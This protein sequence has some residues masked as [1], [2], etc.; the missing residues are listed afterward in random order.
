[1]LLIAR[2]GKIA[3]FETIGFMDPDKK[4]AMKDDAIFRIFSMSKPITSVAA[5][6]L[7]EQ[8]KLNLGDPIAKYLPEFAGVKVMVA[9]K[10]PNDNGAGGKTHLVAPHRAPTVQDLLR[11]TAGLTYGFWGDPVAKL[12]VEA[13]LFGGNYDNAE[14]VSRIAKLPLA[15]QPGTVWNYSN[16]V[17]VLGRV[18][19]VV[20]G[21]SLYRFE[22]ENILDPLGMADTSFYV[23]DP[24]KKDRIAEGLVTDNRVFGFPLFDPTIQGKLE[25]GGQGMESTT[26]DYARFLQMLLNGGELD[27]HRILAPATVAL[28]THDH[29]GSIGPSTNLYLPGPGTG[30]GLGFAVRRSEGV[31]NIAGNVGNYFWGGAAGTT[32]WNDPKMGMLVVFMIQAPRQ[33]PHYTVVLPDMVYAALTDPSK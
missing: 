24:A 33:G 1:T 2:H 12:Y 27:E 19:E 4:V 17:D 3:Y 22:K 6:I 28:M 23:T 18:V 10:D 21:K 9:N 8:G 30:F 15:F 11:H 31:A 16:G 20:S 14:F 13:G 5:M 26:M 25:A 32:F 7:V 29:L